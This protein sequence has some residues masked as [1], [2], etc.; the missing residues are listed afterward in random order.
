MTTEVKFKS[1]PEF[2]QKELYGIKPNTIRKPD[3]SHD[4]RFMLLEEF[5]QGTRNVLFIRIENTI[6]GDSFR[7]KINDVSFYAGYYI[8][9]WRVE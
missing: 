7:R 6:N 4:P 2:Y 8:I 9:S 5:S 1:N 3:K